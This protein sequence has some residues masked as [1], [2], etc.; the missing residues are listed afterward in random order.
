MASMRG[1]TPFRLVRAP[2]NTTV[3]GGPGGKGV[4]VRGTATQFEM[5]TIRSA[6]IRRSSALASPWW[7]T[8]TWTLIRATRR[9]V[10]RS[11]RAGGNTWPARSKAWSSTMI[12]L[13]TAR[14]ATT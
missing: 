3:N 6:G 5:T 14:T 9:S 8:T 4:G 1:G 7:S 2:T 12:G 13:P 10:H 11:V